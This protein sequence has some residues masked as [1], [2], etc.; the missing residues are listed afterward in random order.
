M[1]AQPQAGVEPRK[2]GSSLPGGGAEG[3]KAERRQG[4]AGF[5][6]QPQQPPPGQQPSTGRSGMSHLSSQHNSHHRSNH[7]HQQNSH[8]SQQPPRQVQNK[9]QQGVSLPTPQNKSNQQQPGSPSQ[10]LSRQQHA[11]REQGPDSS[12]GSHY[13]SNQRQNST[14]GLRHGGNRLSGTGN[15]DS[16]S[17]DKDLKPHRAQEHPKREVAG[18]ELSGPNPAESETSLSQSLKA[19]PSGPDSTSNEPSSKRTEHEGGERGSGGEGVK[20]K[21]EA[22]GEDSGA[23]SGK[24][25]REEGGRSELRWG[26][27]K[28]LRCVRSGSAGSAGVAVSWTADAWSS[29]EE[30]PQQHPGHP[31]RPRQMSVPEGLGDVE[32]HASV[33]DEAQQDPDDPLEKKAR[34]GTSRIRHSGSASSNSSGGQGSQWLEGKGSESAPSAAADGSHRGDKDH[35]AI[36]DDSGGAGAARGGEEKGEGGSDLPR[37]TKD[38][39]HSKSWLKRYCTLNPPHEPPPLPFTVKVARQLWLG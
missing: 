6:S 1:F 24:S 18:P 25:L 20:V 38:H 34:K 29:R 13:H 36:A 21:R 12:K 9:Q 23:E 15:D 28:R 26:Q 4:S 22:P 37:T 31:P 30:N 5:D 39:P 32:R 2:Q 8:H 17:E 33:G 11:G 27:R 10:T 14:G 16:G 35:R 19:E 7:H 3:V